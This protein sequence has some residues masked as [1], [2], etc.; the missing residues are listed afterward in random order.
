MLL[1]HA[2]RSSAP[3]ALANVPT[4]LAWHLEQDNRAAYQYLKQALQCIQ[5]QK[6]Q[7]GEA[8]GRWVLKAPEHMSHLPLLFEQFPKATVIQP[9]RDPVEIYPSLASMVFELR[10]LASD[11][12]DP[13]AAAAYVRTSSAHRIT[14]LL[15]ARRVLPAERF[16]DIWF[17][18]VMSDPIGQVGN[19]YEQ[20]G[21]DFTH[22][23]KQCMN[24]WLKAN[25][26]DQRPI[27]EYTLE[28]F[29]F[30]AEEIRHDLAEY[31]EAYV[32]PFSP[33]AR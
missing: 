21:L 30:V 3:A 32:L 1:E 19:I 11:C 24:A 2:F 23:A 29:G 9:H 15:E 20:L 31:R 16:I 8:A 26:R 27:H 4:Y 18:D 14:R 12:V 7:R 22:E 33:H 6:R 5:W 13:A 28:Q 10:R 17:K 25:R